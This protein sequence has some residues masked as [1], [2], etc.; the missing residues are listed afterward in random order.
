[1][2]SARDVIKRAMR[3]IGVIAAGE[4]PSAEEAADALRE[5]NGMMTNFPREGIDYA[6]SWLSLTD[7]LTIDDGLCDYV[8]DCL[9]KRIAT[10]Y[11]RPIGPDI[12]EAADTGRRMLQAAFKSPRGADIDYAIS[13]PGNTRYLGFGDG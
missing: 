12:E 5:L 11:G 8:G 13:R 9:A 10:E 6:H 4:D 2:A 1:M 3:R 7:V